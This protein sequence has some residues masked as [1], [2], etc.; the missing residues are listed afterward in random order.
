MSLCKR[1]LQPFLVPARTLLQKVSIPNGWKETEKKR[2]RGFK[3]FPKV[4]ACLISLFH[5]HR[6]KWEMKGGGERWFLTPSFF[7]NF[8]PSSIPEQMCALL[9]LFCS[10]LNFPP[11]FHSPLGFAASILSPFWCGAHSRQVCCKWQNSACLP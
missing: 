6:E 4:E 11:S 7:R 9:L 10:R 3:S 2:E 5:L 8:L 1:S